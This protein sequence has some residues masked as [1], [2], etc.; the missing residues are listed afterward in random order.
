MKLFQQDL[1]LWRKE[2]TPDWLPERTRPEG[3]NALAKRLE[4]RADKYLAQEL[5]SEERAQLEAV[6]GMKAYLERRGKSEVQ[7]CQT[8]TF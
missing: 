8:V 6:R 5:S 1:D 4:R 7:R 2:R 3:E